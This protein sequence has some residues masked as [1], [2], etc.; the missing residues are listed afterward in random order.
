MT[1]SPPAERLLTELDQ[2][3]L[4]RVLRDATAVAHTATGTAL[5]AGT[6]ALEHLLDNARVV[7]SQAIDADVVTM[8][9]EVLL[10]ADGSADTRR[11]TIR[12]PAEADPVH[13]A[14][15][16]LSPAGVGILGSRVGSQVAWQGPDGRPQA[17]RIAALLYQP[18]RSGDLLR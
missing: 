16:V 14:V 1:T 17:Y 5:G 6:D 12:Y 11:L 15:S 13:G 8:N 3:R 4:E 10:E 18:E 7:P 9:S 2:A